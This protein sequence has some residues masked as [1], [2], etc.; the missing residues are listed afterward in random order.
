MLQDKSCHKTLFQK[1]IEFIFYGNY[2]YG[3][4]VVSLMIETSFQMH[5]LYKGVFIYCMAF[6][7]TV[8]FYNYPYARNYVPNSKNPRTQWYVR[9]HGL[10]LKTQIS[11]TIFVLILLIFGM[12]YYHE[13]IKMIRFFQWFL[14]LI[15]PVFG[16]MYYGTNVIS[17]K[18]NLRKIGWLKPF[19]IGFVWAGIATIYPVIFNDILQFHKSELSL[20]GTLL[21]FKNVMFISLLAI[22]FDVKDFASDR[23]ANLSTL[24][25]KIGLFKTIFY[26][27]LPLTVLGIL[28]FLTYAI[29]HNFSI[30]KIILVLIPFL[31]LILSAISLKKR[32][33]L[34]YYLIVI[35][36]LMVIKAVFGVFAALV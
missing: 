33:T 3:I 29:T 2:F 24:V 19:I 20:F 8:L 1:L 26:V 4:C 15:F 31:L 25:V 10:V 6:I 32:R 35:D 11:L 16:A 30:L 7:V 18:Y 28:T 5:I 14:F 23:H 17:K 12:I 9:N 27:L 13:E 21:F 36:G 34:L 22:M